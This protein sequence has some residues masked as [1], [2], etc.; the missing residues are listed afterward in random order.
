M[1]GAILVV[2]IKQSIRTLHFDQNYESIIIGTAVVV[3][4]V[5]DQTSARLSAKRLAAASREA[6]LTKAN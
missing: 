2:L 3:A 4:V 5:L 1:L 6:A